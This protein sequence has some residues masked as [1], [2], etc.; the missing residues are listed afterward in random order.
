M[1]I[2]IN[3]SVKVKPNEKGMEIL[4]NNHRKLSEYFP[5]LGEFNDPRDEDG[6]MKIQLWS[7]MET[8]GPHIRLD[9]LPP[10]DTSIILETKQ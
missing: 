3:D 2:N 7:L 6:Y 10:F 9:A 4:R 1:E 5:S 8:F